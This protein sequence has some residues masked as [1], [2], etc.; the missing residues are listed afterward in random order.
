MGQ[1]TATA[2]VERDGSVRGLVSR[3]ACAAWPNACCQINAQQLIVLVRPL[4]WG[5]LLHLLSTTA[6]P[7]ISYILP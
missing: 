1:E 6:L 5:F 4:T 2:G 3:S 7:E